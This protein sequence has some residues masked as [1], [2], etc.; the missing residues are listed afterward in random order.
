M[1]QRG[2][3]ILII[4]GLDLDIYTVKKSIDF[5]IP[6]LFIIYCRIYAIDLSGESECHL[7]LFYESGNTTKLL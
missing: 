7:D 1:D 6:S 5:M 3:Q 2:S 4:I